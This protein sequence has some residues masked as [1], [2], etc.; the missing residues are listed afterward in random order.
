ML[1]LKIT[2]VGTSAGFIL[3]EEVMA[4]LKVQKGDT[5][6]LTETPDGGYH[7]TSSD[8]ELERQL[9]LAEE[10]MNEDHDILQALAK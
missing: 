4:R 3:T 6:Y 10:I 7:L 5:L 2:T 9:A 1:T 8:P